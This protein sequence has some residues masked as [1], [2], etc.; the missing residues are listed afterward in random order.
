MRQFSKGPN[1]L[2]EYRPGMDVAAMGGSLTRASTA[3]YL[4]RNGVF[5]TAAVDEL[6]DNSWRADGIRRTKLEGA[7]TNSAL[8]SNLFGDSTY[9]AQSAQFAVTSVP[10]CIAGQV[11]WQHIN[12][13]GLSNRARNQNIGVFVNGQS[14]CASWIIKPNANVADQALVTV[15]GIRDQVVGDWVNIVSVT[16]ATLAVQQIGGTVGG[17]AG[18]RALGNGW[19][20]VYVVAAGTATGAGTA[21]NTRA[22]YIYPNGTSGPGSTSATGITIAHGQLE[23]AQ[24]FP[25][26]P[27]IT[28]AAPVT[29]AAD[30]FQFPFLAV[31]QAMT[32]YAKFIECG[33]MFGGTNSWRVFQIGSSHPR[34]ILFAGSN[35]RYN[36]QWTN[37]LSAVVDVAEVPAI[38][39]GDQVELSLNL[40]PNGSIQLWDSINNGTPVGSAVSAA[41][42]LDAAWDQTILHVNSANG[43]A[44][45]FIEFESIRIIAG[46]RSFAE[47]AYDFFTAINSDSAESCHLIELE[48]STGTVYLTTAYQD[49]AW[50]GNTYEAVGGLL[51]IGGI[52]ETSDPQGQGVDLKLSAVDQTVLAALMSAQYRGREA[53]VYR[54]HLNK[55]TGQVVGDPFLMLRGLQLSNYQI[56]E[57]RDASGGT[58]TISTRISGYLSIDRV[59]GIKSNLTSHQHEFPGDTFWQNAAILANTKIYW[60]TPVPQTPGGNSSSH[61]DTSG[62]TGNGGDGY[63]INGNT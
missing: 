34:I 53:K 50:N 4:D 52:E 45:G 46:S 35:A 2:F 58:V 28:V 38:A 18:I 10:S 23:A 33:T 27:I 1:V 11:A 44:Q 14:D 29:R 43:F 39:F 55:G 8:G 17:T 25:S 20:Q 26:S 6:R 40:N 24:L 12:N 63:L 60:G 47:V 59:R 13:T 51:E 42:A 32:M 61:T 19:Y 36:G 37:G 21:G 30:F 41:Q 7:S 16:W 9:W 22:M 15:F 5:Q 48:F 57:N 31:P 49:I 3:T 54:A 56:E 62:Q